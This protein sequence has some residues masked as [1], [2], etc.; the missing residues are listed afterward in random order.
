M[1][2]GPFDYEHPP[3]TSSLWIAEG[4][5]QL[6]RRADRGAIRVQARPKISCKGC[7]VAHRSAFKTRRAGWCSRSSSRRLRS[8]PPAR[9]EW[10]E[11]RDKVVD[12]CIEGPD[13]GFSCSRRQNSSLQP[14]AR[15][16]WM[17]S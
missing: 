17:T 15:R 1:E 2:L 9:P 14:Q 11:D 6:L 8:G 16:A 10:A 7:V 5:T 13:R 12:Y 4:F 3:N